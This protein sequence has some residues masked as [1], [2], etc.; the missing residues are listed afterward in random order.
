MTRALK[1]AL[2]IAFFL[3]FG[4]FFVFLGFQSVELHLAR[5]PDGRVDATVTR[6]HFLGLYRV[7]ARASGVKA[8]T[9]E[10]RRTSGS[11]TRPGGLPRVTTSNVV[12]EAASGDLPLFTCYSNVDEAYRRTIARRLNVFLGRADDARL[13]E[14]FRVRNVFGW[15]GL[16]FLLVG[17]LGLLGWPLTL[18]RGRRG[19]P[20]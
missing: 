10:T 7:T 1:A 12:L 2:A 13:S 4:G 15:V 14:V 19:P 9:I 8:A 18:L 16:P 3:G 20:R 6:H 5:G 11:A 17:L